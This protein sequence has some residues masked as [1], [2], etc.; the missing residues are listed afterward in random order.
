MKN[1]V[2]KGDVLTVTAPANVNAGDGVLVG[3]FFGVAATTQLSGADVEIETYG[4]YDLTALSTDTATQGAK[5]YW[6]NTNKRITTTA[7]GNTLVGAFTKA[8]AAGE[9]T[10]RVKVDASVR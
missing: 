1:F 6:D 8:K 5:A 10:G 9:T 3:S 7:S 4:V 2:Q